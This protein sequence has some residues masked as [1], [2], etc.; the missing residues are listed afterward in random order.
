[1]LE[2]KDFSEECEIFYHT[3][4]DEKKAGLK[5]SIKKV[6]AA[7]PADEDKAQRKAVKKRKRDEK[8]DRRL[9]REKRRKERENDPVKME[10]RTPIKFFNYG[11]ING[12]VHIGKLSFIIIYNLYFKSSKFIC[13]IIVIYHKFK[14]RG[15]PRTLW[16]EGPNQPCTSE[17]HDLACLY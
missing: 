6:V 10:E 5:F 9:K 1:M 8:Q 15:A 11:T 14:S 7:I 13:Q 2:I 3:V 16:P 4:K 12:T 17:A